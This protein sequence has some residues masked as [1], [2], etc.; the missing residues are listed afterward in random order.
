MD[1]CTLYSAPYGVRW[2]TEKITKTC[3]WLLHW[4]STVTQPLP[5]QPGDWT[6]K[7]HQSYQFSECWSST[8]LEKLQAQVSPV[9]RVSQYLIR[10]SNCAC[11]GGLW[12]ILE[13]ESISACLS[14]TLINPYQSVKRS[15]SMSLPE[16]RPLVTAHLAH[17]CHHHH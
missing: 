13:S 9:S 12:I 16:T 17:I 4:Y 14:L 10:A 2:P 7:W 8:A 3:V 1:V 5:G 15:K 11:G 6:D